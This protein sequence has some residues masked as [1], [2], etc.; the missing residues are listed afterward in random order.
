M[1]IL[2]YRAVTIVAPKVSLDFKNSIIIKKV[3]FVADFRTI[4]NTA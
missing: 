3:L 4:N 2:I 1:I